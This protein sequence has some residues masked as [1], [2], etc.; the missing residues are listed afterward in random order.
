MTPS[1]FPEFDLGD[2]DVE[3]R[4]AAL[5][6]R[7][8]NFD[9]ASFDRPDWRR[10]DYRQTLPSE[11]PGAPEPGGSWETAVA[12]SRSYAF[13][14]P[15]LVEARYDP[16]VPLEE[17]VMLLILHV[18]GARIYAGV[19]VGA[20]GNDL[21][22]DHEREAQVFFWNYR[23]LE[24]HVEA[25]QRDF[26][27]WKWHDTGEV[28]FRT[29]AVS[30]AADT[31]P[32]IRLGFRLLGR[33]KQVEFGRRACMRIALLTE[34][35]LRQPASTMSAET[36]DGRLLAIYARDHH[37][38]LVALRELAQRMS[39]ANRPAEQHAFA[40]EVQQAAKSD[41]VCLEEF[42]R[43]LESAPSRARHATV[44]TAEKLGRLKLNG[45][46]LR[47]SPLS[48]VTEIEGCRLLLESTR[49]L[50]TAIARLAIG[51]AD[52]AERAHRANQLLATAEQ[53]RLDAIQHA[54]YQPVRAA[55]GARSRR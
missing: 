23:T 13:A 18:F 39:T 21:R 32:I 16:T 17:R 10:D 22:I 2:G 38:L 26:E 55:P 40:H 35:G 30:R 31:N 14:D 27:V 1:R 36:L 53:L 34:A 29:H 6:G 46:I 9:P 25:G 5:H 28:E 8:L 7:P 52:A 15:S 3:A 41:V 11:R 48:A 4:L 24:G 54:T 51:P 19:R 50:W 33:H 37:A 43:R 47:P 42:L 45:R 49:A 12:L 44:W 20:T